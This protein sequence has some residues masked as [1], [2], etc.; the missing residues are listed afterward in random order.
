MPE[1]ISA[2]L[3]LHWLRPWAL[4]GLPAALWLWVGGR[5]APSQQ[6]LRGVIDEHLLAHLLVRGGRARWLRP[7]DT[8]AVALMCFCVALAGPAW[9]REAAPLAQEEAALMLVLDL[10]P[11]MDAVDW[12]PSRLAR[13]RAKLHSLLQQRGDAPTGLLVYA[14][15]AHLVLPPTQDR[16]VLET[17]LD[18]LATTLMP[19]PGLVPAQALQLALSWLDRNPVPGTVLFMTA[20]WPTDDITRAEALLKA[21]KHRLIVWAIGDAKGGPMRGAD[22]RYL[23]DAQGRVQVARLDVATLSALRQR[24]GAALVTA[25]QDDTDLARVQALVARHRAEAVE[26]DPT[27]RWRDGGA[28]WLWPGLAALLLSFRRG[29]VVQGQ[30]MGV[31]FVAGAL[32]L[33]LSAFPLT[34]WAQASAP[35]NAAINAPVSAPGTA[36][37]WR[38][39]FIGWWLT[40]DQLGRWWLQQ[41]QPER[42]AQHFADPFW[43]GFAQ[44]Q[45]GQWQAA[46]DDF[47]RS[48]SAAGW[49]NQAQMLARS[50][51]FS[52]AV[53][54]YDQ[55]LIRAP[56]W[57]QATRDRDLVRGLIPPTQEPQ[58]D[59]AGDPMG[60]ADG[61]Q[62][63]QRRPKKPGPPRPLTESEV[64]ELWLQ[65]LDT[66]PA[67]F[68]QRKFAL[69]AQ[70]PA[71]EPPFK[72]TR[73]GP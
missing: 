5:R 22:G 41:G 10:S 30:A 9:E 38:E 50:G 51:Q 64:A 47:A 23:T 57:P 1:W 36:P 56:G 65:R 15:S 11:A 26:Q 8:L 53:A 42:A 35:V 43:R 68:L 39:R 12:P 45:A 32:S 46:A 73:P 62:P 16:K 52:A 40:P 61:S 59:E 24:T 63:G 49:F 7:S 37:D 2:W 19:Q 3:P 70:L 29:W 31:L 48:D 69:Q 54:A 34:A 66:S 20:E 25:S 4:W 60:D 72:P 18:T 13:A 21:S 27:R 71:A 6:H 55:A 67:G 44:A 28:A 33:W 14:G 58:G 17:Y